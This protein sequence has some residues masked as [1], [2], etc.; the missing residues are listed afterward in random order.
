L[1]VNDEL[2]EVWSTRISVDTGVRSLT[3]VSRAGL[4][5]MKRISGRGQ[6]LVDVAKLE[7]KHDEGT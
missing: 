3:V 7:G 5:I 1:L 6:D 4:A 2:A